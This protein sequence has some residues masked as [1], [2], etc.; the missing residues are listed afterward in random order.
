MSPAKILAEIF[1]KQVE[2]TPDQALSTTESHTI[3]QNTFY[4]SF[5]QA[6]LYP[7]IHWQK[8]FYVILKMKEPD[9]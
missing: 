5:I 6:M 3:I 8:S 4:V 7:E 9:W 2:F 1:D